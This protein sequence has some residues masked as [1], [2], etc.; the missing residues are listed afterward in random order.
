MAI[1]KISIE[2]SAENFNKIATATLARALVPELSQNSQDASIVVILHSKLCSKLTFEKFM[3]TYEK[4]PIRHLYTY[5]KR[6]IV[7]LHSNYAA[8]WLSRNS[9]R[10]ARWMRHSTRWTRPGQTVFK[11]LQNQ[12]TTNYTTRNDCNADFW[13]IY[14]DVRKNLKNMCH[15]KN[16]QKSAYNYMYY[17]EWL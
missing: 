9:T 1:C 12:S 13:E 15:I 6:H 8:N 16:S 14:M 10:I 3:Y 4:R 7:I 17:V 2:L 11:K 5:E